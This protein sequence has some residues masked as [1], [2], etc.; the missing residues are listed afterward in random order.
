MTQATP[1]VNVKRYAL[2]YVATILGLVALSFA[3]TLLAGIT[4]PAG[5][6]T[7]LPA[8]AG[9]MIEGQKRATSGLAPFEKSEAWAAARAMTKVVILVNALIMV[10]AMMVPSVRAVFLTV[11]MM[12]ALVFLVLVGITFLTNRFFLTYGYKNQKIALD[13]KASRK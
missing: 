3:L 2:I 12:A 9:A 13:R 7:I 6:S 11:P 5:L 4:L 8:M 10:L 1:L